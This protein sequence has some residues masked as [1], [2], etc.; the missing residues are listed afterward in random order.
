MK[1]NLTIGFTVEGMFDGVGRCRFRDAL[2]LSARFWIFSC[3]SGS[4]LALRT[5]C[6][7]EKKMK[8]NFT[9]LI[10]FTLEILLTYKKRTLSQY[11][12]PCYP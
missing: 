1:L 8:A 4:T 2:N 6:C 5:I 12:Y 9:K 10:V 3:A 7:L 11:V